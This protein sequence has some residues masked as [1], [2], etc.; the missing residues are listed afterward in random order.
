MWHVGV[1][2]QCLRVTDPSL[3]AC[4]EV[5]LHE[6]PCNVRAAFLS[7]PQLCNGDAQLSYLHTDFYGQQSQG[8]LHFTHMSF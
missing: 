1:Y 2:D 8:G 6:L 3:S 5:Q 4:A 7:C